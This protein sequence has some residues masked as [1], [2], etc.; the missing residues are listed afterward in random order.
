MSVAIRH[1]V[2]LGM[3]AVTVLACGKVSE[4]VSDQSTTSRYFSM[5]QTLQLSD[6]TSHGWSSIPST[7]NA[8]TIYGYA[9]G[10]RLNHGTEKL[11]WAHAVITQKS[12][13]T[14]KPQSH[15]PTPNGSPSVP[16]QSAPST[17]TA[18][19]ASSTVST[20]PTANTVTATKTTPPPPITIT[21][22]D[23]KKNTVTESRYKQ[24]YMT[25]K[26]VT[27]SV[28][29]G[30]SFGKLLPKYDYYLTTYYT[31]ANTYVM[32]V[33]SKPVTEN[34]TITPYT[35]IVSTAFITHLANIAYNADAVIPLSDFYAIIPTASIT[36][37]QS[38]MI[39]NAARKFDV[40][41]PIF[42]PKSPY[43][44]ALLTVINLVRS[45]PQTDVLDYIASVDDT[46]FSPA[47]KTVYTDHISH[48]FE[49]KSA[50]SDAAKTD[51]TDSPDN[52]APTDTTLQPPP[53][54]DR[55][56]SPPLTQN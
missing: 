26:T 43:I 10:I 35:H 19:E 41:Q 39:P 36:P 25:A 12:A 27:E 37:T 38:V 54:L 20:Q 44:N 47:V 28:S 46:I 15:T 17:R 16:D 42:I 29:I 7:Q 52:D 34:I 5:N 2:Y 21:N 55:S 49:T 50:S 33:E 14:P 48:Y 13:N 4:D 1:W 8:L 6:V 30:L 3:M 18:S 51:S 24:G 23:T 9:Q 45:A 40:N 56:P 22:F 53:T 31:D 32:R 11:G